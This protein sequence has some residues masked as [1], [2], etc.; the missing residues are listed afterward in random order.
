DSFIWQRDLVDAVGFLTLR[1]PLIGITTATARIR[2]PVAREDLGQEGPTRHTDALWGFAFDGR[3]W[4]KKSRQP[5]E[6]ADSMLYTPTH[7]GEQGDRIRLFRTIEAARAAGAGVVYGV[8]ARPDV[9]ARRLLPCW[10]DPR[11]F[12]PA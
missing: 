9:A 5:V 8:A 10:T 1:C 3:F 4:M 12:N 11:A 6:R 7:H 2:R